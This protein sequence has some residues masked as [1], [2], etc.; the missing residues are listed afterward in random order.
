MDSSHTPWSNATYS[1][2]T[3]YDGWN[4]FDYQNPTVTR[5]TTDL[6]AGAEW[7]AYLGERAVIPLRAGVFREPQ[8]IVDV[9]TG[10]Q[11]VLQGWTA[12]A[13]IKFA[14]LT[15]DLAYKVRPRPCASCPATPP[16]R[17][18]AGWP[19]PAWATRA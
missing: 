1:P 7:I 4:W 16:T 9:V 11:R 3:S 13:G 19:P 5:N 18:L 17:R 10:A 2:G 15:I 14:D 8:P 12:G 6:H